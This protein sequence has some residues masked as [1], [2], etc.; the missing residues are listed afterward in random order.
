M[1]ASR[2]ISMSSAKG[3]IDNLDTISQ[4]LPDEINID[5][6]YD[7]N[8]WFWIESDSST[9]N[10]NSSLRGAL[11]ELNMPKSVYQTLSYQEVLLFIKFVSTFEDEKYHIHMILQ[12]ISNFPLIWKPLP[13]ELM[14]HKLPK[15]IKFTQNEEFYQ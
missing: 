14:E 4:C 2:K 10:S 1:N 8:D 11:T 7:E 12:L 15:S 3:F 5:K 13:K 6:T 9:A